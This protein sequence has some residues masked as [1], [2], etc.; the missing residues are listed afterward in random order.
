MT[1]RFQHTV[2]GR[3]LV[4]RDAVLYIDTPEGFAL[5][6][7][8]AAPDLPGLLYV[9]GRHD[10]VIDAAG[11]QRASGLTAPQRAALDAVIDRA[12]ELVATQ[13]A[14]LAPPPPDDA[15]RARAKLADVDRDSV[16]ALRAWVAARA[17][18]P[19]AVRDLEAVYQAERAKLGGA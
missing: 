5:D 4:Q 13:A 17:D 10:C 19:Q 11:H 16:A 2:D 14:R 9:P 1:R 6:V 7:G 3:V 12:A 15:A 18:A 8:L